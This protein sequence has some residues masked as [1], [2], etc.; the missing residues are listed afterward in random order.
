M[1]VEVSTN[2]TFP[3]GEPKVLYKIPAGVTV[4]II[5]A[6]HQRAL[7]ATPTAQASAAPF[8]VVLNW[9]AML[10]K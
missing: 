2:P 7:V 10:K 1:A 3:F 8:T 4:G 6:D 5:T 9:Q